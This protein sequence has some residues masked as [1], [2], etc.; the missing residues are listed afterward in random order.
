[1]SR[2]SIRVISSAIMGALLGVACTQVPRADKDIASSAFPTA[3]R[4]V[5]PITSS[6]WSTED[7][8][9]KVSESQVVMDMAGVKPGMTAADIGAG[10]GYYTVRLAARVGAKGRVL[11][12]DIMPEVRDKLGARVYRDRLDNVSVKLGAANDPMLPLN[13]FDRVFMIHMYHEI[14]APLEFLWRLRPSIRAGG[15]V[16]IVDS[17]R[18][19]ANH[20]IPPKLLA[21]EF[22]AVGY[23]LRETH[24]MP[25]KG[26]YLT[27]FAPSGKRPQPGEIKPCKA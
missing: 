3:D 7:A 5:S 13:S 19:T 26:T 9:D 16:I 24:P 8:R 25:Q 4:P 10:E 23:A 6:R 18:P 12:Q 17:D 14:G 11:A 1:M 2:M 20:G 22:A 21:C 27:I 15:S